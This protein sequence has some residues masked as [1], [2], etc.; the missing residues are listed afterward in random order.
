MSCGVA[1]KSVWPDVTH[2]RA[3]MTYWPSPKSSSQLQTRSVPHWANGAL[4]SLGSKKYSMEMTFLLLISTA[5]PTLQSNLSHLFAKIWQYC[6]YCDRR[7]GNERQGWGSFG[8]SI[9]WIG[10]EGGQVNL[11]TAYKNQSKQ[12]ELLAAQLRKDAPFPLQR[13]MGSSAIYL[14]NIY[15]LSRNWLLFIIYQIIKC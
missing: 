8:S 10:L 5:F 13:W 6:D 14:N 12:Q 1:V 11:A 9:I 3:N 2:C 4:W 15:F 7:M